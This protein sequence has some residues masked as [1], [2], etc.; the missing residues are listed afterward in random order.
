VLP[1][2]IANALGFVPPS[3]T[4]AKVTT[5]PVLL[6]SVT[7]CTLL[8]VPVAW[9]PNGMLPVDVVTVPATPFP[10][11]VTVC[12][13]PVVPL[14]SS[15]MVNV[16]VRAPIASGA[17]EMPI[18][19]ACP[20]A[21]LPSAWHV[22]V[23][24]IA[25]SNALV[26]LIVN[27]AKLKRALPLLVT[28]MYCGALVTLTAWLVNVSG[29]GV[30]TAVGAVP[31]PV[32]GAFG[33]PVV[34]K[35][36]TPVRAPAAFGVKE[37]STVQDAPV[38][39]VCSAQ[40]SKLMAKSAAFAP[41]MVTPG[42]PIVSVVAVPFVSVMLSNPGLT[43][44]TGTFPN[45]VGD[46]VIV[47]VEVPVPLIATVRGVPESLN[48]TFS[49]ALLAPTALGSNVGVIVQ[50]PPFFASVVTGVNPCMH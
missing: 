18:V 6:V 9:L 15:F 16:P 26:P 22:P 23:A 24:V 34:L 19:Q 13:L 8:V 14:L 33:E 46:C 31:V 5:D 39:N 50:P 12:V 35:V 41:E 30:A 21:K 2:A 48:V 37:T 20:A 3:A 49:V 29:F 4:L 45:V 40:P 25:K 47:T 1:L 17:N 32:I 38:V 10:F 7:V 42:V 36:I 43:E 28:V 27:P 44:F 11:N